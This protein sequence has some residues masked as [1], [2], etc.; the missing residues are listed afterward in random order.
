MNSFFANKNDMNTIDAFEQQLAKQIL[1]SERK[2]VTILAVILSLMALEVFTISFYFPDFF[3]KEFLDKLYGLQLWNW[4]N[5]LLVASAAYEWLIRI[6]INNAIKKGEQIS[7]FLRYINVFVETS[8][9]TVII[10]LV[11]QAIDPALAL[12]APPSFFYF[13]FIILA[14]LRLDFKLCLFTGTVAAIE[15]FLLALL[16]SSSISESTHATLLTSLPP[17]VVKAIVLFITGLVTGLITLQLRRQIIHSFRSVQER[18]DIANIFGQHVSPAVVEKLLHQPTEMST[19]IRH[20][21]VM[22]L[23]IRDFTTFSE[24]HPPEEIVNFLNILFEPM[25]EIVNR[26]QGVIN[27]F[28]GDGFMAIFGAPLSDGKDSQHAIDAAQEI[29]ETVKQKILKDEIPPIRIGIGLHTGQAVTGN[30]GSAQRKEYTVIGDVVNL[31]SRIEQLNK[32]F[33]SQLLIS[34]EVWNVII[35]EEI[36]VIDK[37]LIQVKGR[38]ES[39]K[40][41]QISECNKSKIYKPHRCS[42]K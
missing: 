19:E 23:D 41:Y 10:F 4:I 30:V 15:Y 31:A 28:L 8:L 7:D 38:K 1:I 17:H 26:H 21:C 24:K 34:A 25:I 3:P 35:Q 13:I 6:F 2:R 32:Q 29:I 33:N 37:G 9:P 39:V 14:S 5:L 42:D 12:V 18:N 11:A 16:F 36:N 22:F 40:I 20:V 27:K